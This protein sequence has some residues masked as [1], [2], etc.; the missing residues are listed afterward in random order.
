MVAETTAAGVKKGALTRELAEFCAGLEFGDLPAAVKDHAKMLILDALGCCL[1][2]AT[3]PWTQIV[4]DLVRDEGGAQEA[5]LIGMPGRFPATS[6]VL[7]NST[8]GHGFEMDDIHRDAIIHPNSLTVPSALAVAERNGGASGA[9]FIA[10][11]VAGYEVAARIGRT[12]GQSLLLKGFHPQGTTG[13][14]AATATAARML[15]LDAAQVRH[16]LGVG[17]SLGAGL[18]AA[19]EGAMVKR[20]HSG[21]AAQ[22]GVQAALLA[23]R[24]F[25]GIDDVIEAD[26]GGFLSTHAEGADPAELT[27]ELG[28][29]W[30]IL[31]SGYKLYPTVTSIHNALHALRALMREHHIDPNAIKAIDVGVSQATYVHAAWPYH[32]QSVTAAQ[33]NLFYGLSVMAFEGRVTTAEFKPECIADPVVLAYAERI[34][35]F[36]DP[37]IEALGTAH[38][39]AANV[40]VSLASGEAHEMQLRL[41]PGSPESPADPEDVRE[42]FRHNAAFAL[43]ADA[44]DKIETQVG[45]LDTLD[46]VRELAALL[47][48]PQA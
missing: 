26:Y 30:E 13:A 33:M 21:R 22:A 43:D 46:D 37:E 20:L 35:A 15:G 36:V 6:A 28:E 48:P 19:Q 14:F 3:L 42:K 11:V 5:T 23:A 41:R 34:N 31:E 44:I 18:I 47:V 17:G 1:Q 12:A 9:N 32:A 16:A 25:T 38:R 39:H 45:A 24:G 7:V 40:K 4:A 10:A 27:R 29:A 2:G 8:A